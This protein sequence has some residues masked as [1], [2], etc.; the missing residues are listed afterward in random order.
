MLVFSSNVPP[1]ST[2]NRRPK[3]PPSSYT[4]SLSTI[5]MMTK[6]AASRVSIVSSSQSDP[7]HALRHQTQLE[8]RLC[9]HRRLHALAGGCAGAE[10][11][12]ELEVRRLMLILQ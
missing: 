9:P 4:A 12:C 5:S 2:D 11:S 10:H 7:R 1:A 3:R 6:D 8:V